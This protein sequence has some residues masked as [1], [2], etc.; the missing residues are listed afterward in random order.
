MWHCVFG[1]LV[2]NI[3]KDCVVFKFWVK[4]SPPPKKYYF[5]LTMKGM[6][7]HALGTTH[8]MTQHHILEDLNPQQNIMLWQVRFS[9][10]CIVWFNNHKWNTTAVK[11]TKDEIHVAANLRLRYTVTILNSYLLILR[12]WT[13]H[14]TTEYSITH[15]SLI[16]ST[17][18]QVH[19]NN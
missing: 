3:S 2:P 18:K 13:V 14:D 5:S 4:Q 6:T 8:P 12:L 1:W 9:C 16:T 10:A 17:S 11:L 7:F 19:G 15:Q